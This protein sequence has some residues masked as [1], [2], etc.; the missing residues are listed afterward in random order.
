MKLEGSLPCSQVPETGPY[1]HFASNLLVKTILICDYRSQIFESF[2]IFK[3]FTTRQQIAISF[4]LVAR[5]NYIGNVPFPAHTLYQPPYYMIMRLVSFQLL[6]L[7]YCTS[8]NQFRTEADV[9]H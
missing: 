5:H 2:H 9:F 3:G 6:H 8:S 1:P 4:L 7:C